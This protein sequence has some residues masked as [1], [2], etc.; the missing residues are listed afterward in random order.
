MAITRDSRVLQIIPVLITSCLLTVPAHAKYD[1]GTGEPNTPYLIYTPEQMNAIGAN[2]DDLDKQF[3]L[4]A[5]I[6]LATLGG[7]P[8]NRIGTD[9]NSPFRGTFDGNGHAIYNFVWTSGKSL[10][11]GLF[12][13]VADPGAEIRNLRLIA[14]RIDVYGGV[15]AGSLV[16]HL[17]EGTLLNCHAENAEVHGHWGSMGGLVGESGSQYPTPG[18]YA[19]I[20]N[21]SCTGRISEEFFTA[22]GLV[23]TDWCGSYDE[24]FTAG[25]VSSG[26]KAGGLVGSA[27]RS[28]FL[29]CYSTSSVTDAP[30]IGG[31][32][33]FNT[34]ATITKCYSAGRVTSLKSAEGLTSKSFGGTITASFWDAQVSD[35]L[36]EADAM[37]R[38]TAQMQDPNMFIAAGWNF[39]GKPDG[40]GDIWVEPAGGGYPML[41]W[42]LPEPPKLPFSAG[43]G[44]PDDPYLIATAEQLNSIGHNP[45]LM[46]AHLR[47]IDNLDLSGLRFYPIGNEDYPFAGVFDGGAFAIS[48]FTY[49]AVEPENVGLFRA[50][51]ATGAEVR[52]IR[53]INPVIDGTNA[54]SVGALAGLLWR[55]TIRDCHVE[56]G[57][58]SGRALVGGLVGQNG[59]SMDIGHGIV[60]AQLVNCGARTAVAGQAIVGGLVGVNASTAMVSGCYAEDDVSGKQNVGG[61]VGM[62]FVAGIVIKSHSGGTIVGEQSVGGLVGS[63]GYSDIQCSFS[64][65]EVRG[66]TRVGGLVGLNYGTATNCYAIAT[67][68]GSDKVGGFAGQNGYISTHGNDLGTIAQCYSASHFS[69]TQNGGGFIGY[70]ELGKVTACFWDIEASGLRPPFGTTTSQMQTA[71]T[72]LNAGWDF[73]DETQNG[74]E[75][76]WWILEGQD[77]PRLSW[78]RDKQP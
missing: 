38:T 17:K 70:N 73:V 26:T 31:L 33:G 42:Q 18:T 71:S 36:K 21:C 44:T 69:A 65:A 30:V 2:P 77:Y 54:K 25:E 64:T 50:I 35:R 58:V 57:R 48:N 15:R 49:T 8:F 13:V 66:T 55:G 72:F 4:M 51:W 61:L 24:C 32:V 7:S 5:D 78:E 40:P 37:G 59:A 74:T 6:D 39:V 3:R 9:P 19:T 20:R 41:W 34:E 23:G 14:P 67:V 22:G 62:N 53:L 46:K 63:N 56:G 16:G 47:V 11:V 12:G 45:R 52:N 76:I 10:N 75:D 68:T 60:W 1:G 28:R 29:N 43:T 27:T